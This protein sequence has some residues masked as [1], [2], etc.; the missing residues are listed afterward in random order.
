MLTLI[1]HA[2]KA[3]KA[4]KLLWN[5]YETMKSMRVL[6]LE[7]QL[8]SEKLANGEAIDLFLTRIK[9]LRD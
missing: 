6:N 9:G 5:Q 3:C 1:Q 2:L 4:W 8:Q 7:N